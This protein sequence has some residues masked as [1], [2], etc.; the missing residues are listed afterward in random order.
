V[1]HALQEQA[2]SPIWGWFGQKTPFAFELD[3]IPTEGVRRFLV[4]SPPILS[5]LAL[6]A[7]LDLQIEAGIRRIRQ[8]S[9]ALTSYLIYLVDSVLTPLGF[10][11]GSPR[12]PAQRGSHISIRHPEGYRINRALIEEMQVLPDFRE[13]DHIRLGLAPLYTTFWEVWAGVERIRRVVDEGH[14]QRFS[15]HRQPVT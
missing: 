2:L 5:L 11:L 13:P 1:N 12:D 4:S 8:K 14:Y 9:I 6:E 3:Y 10:T 15:N 7:G